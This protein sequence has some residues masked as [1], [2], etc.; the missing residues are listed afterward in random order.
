[1]LYPDTLDALR[2][3]RAAGVRIAA[4]SNLALPYAAPLKALLGDL[5][6]VWHLY[7]RSSLTGRST[8]V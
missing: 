1:M 2:R 6:D 3:V 5:V 8:P 7:A 4:A